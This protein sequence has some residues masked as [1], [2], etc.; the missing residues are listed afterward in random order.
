MSDADRLQ[1]AALY[2]EHY[3]RLAGWA[4]TVLGSDADGHDVASEAFTRLYARWRGVQDPRKFLFAVAANLIKDRWRL[5]QRDQ[6]LTTRLHQ[7]Q[8]SWLVTG[9]DLGI[10]DLVGRLPER[11]RL[12][13]L[14]HY[15]ADLPVADV[16][17]ILHRPAGT[18]RRL[19]VEG[20]SALAAQLNEVP[21]A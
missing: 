1:A 11:L 14:L 12:P 10:A 5:V 15:Y 3:P 2:D 6:A 18:V 8:S 21:D 13:I 17:A 7:R 19:L 16:A 20:R 4:A 9:P